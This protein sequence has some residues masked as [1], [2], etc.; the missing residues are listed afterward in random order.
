MLAIRNAIEKVT[1]IGAKRAKGRE[2]TFLCDPHGQNRGKRAHSLIRYAAA[3]NVS[4]LD[5]KPQLDHQHH[6]T[7]TGCSDADE[8]PWC[9][10]RFCEK[11]ESHRE[12]PLPPCVVDRTQK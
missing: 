5:P 11:L 8:R 9:R 6:Q 3:L 1:K 10:Q 7:Q 2:C 4:D 12:L